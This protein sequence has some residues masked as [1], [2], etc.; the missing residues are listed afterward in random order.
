MPS[1]I[2]KRTEKHRMIY[3]ISNRNKNKGLVRLIETKLKISLAKKGKI[4]WNKGLKG[5]QKSTLKGKKLP[6]KSGINHPKWISDRTKLLKYNGSEERRSP[7]YKN[8]RIN[9]FKRD[10]FI[11][12]L[13]SS[14]C[15]GKIEAHHILSWRNY[16]EL[17]FIIN[18]GITLCHFHH[19]RKR[20]EEKRMIPIF[21]EL[22]SVSSE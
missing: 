18:N 9:I 1:G 14:E 4:P 12:S 15:N 8:W 21:Q 6:N 3:S 2:Y 10:K 20:E 7:A 19:P 16:P 5:V 13:K 11:C 17:R 22:L